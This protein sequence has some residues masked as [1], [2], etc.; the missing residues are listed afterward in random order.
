MKPIT[1]LIILTALLIGLPILGATSAG[2]PI[3]LYLE[4]PPHTRYVQ[5]APFS[6]SVFMLVGTGALLAVAAFIYL[7]RPRRGEVKLSAGRRQL[8]WWGWVSGILIICFWTLAWT[9]LEWF[10]PLQSHT[11]TPLWVSYVVFM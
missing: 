10:K 8:P 4:F 3:S 7:Y 2:Y 6:W 11:F 1:P 5:H 9:R